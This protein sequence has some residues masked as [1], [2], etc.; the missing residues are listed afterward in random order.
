[1]SHQSSLIESDILK[2]L[3]QQ[4]HKSLLRFITCGSV[5]DGKSTLIGR[6]LYESKLIYDDQLAALETD[7]K[8]MG[9]QGQGIDFALLVDGLASER[10]QG[11]T[12]DVAYRFF[13]TD[14]RKFIVADTPGHEQYTRNMATGASTADLAILMVDA[15][16]GIQTQTRRHST[17]V[18]MLGVGQMVLAINKMDLVGHSQERYQAIVDDYMAFASSIGI[19]NVTAIPVS[20]LQGDNITS[21][22]PNMPWYTGKSLMGFL[23]TVPLKPVKDSSA[24]TMPV[25]WVNRPHLDFR[26]FAGQITTGSISVGDTIQVLPKKVTSTVKSIVTFEN[27]LT[28]AIRGQSVTLTLTD[29]IDISRGDVLVPAESTVQ[30]GSRFLSTLLWMSEDAMVPG[31]SYWVKTRA[32]L[33]SATISVPKHQLNV[34]T[35]EKM[36]ASTLVLN[37]IGDCVCEFDQDIPVSPY[38]DNPHLGSF[39]IIDRATNN[40]VGMGL[41]RTLLSADNWVADHVAH[42][43]KYWQAGLVDAQQ[44]AGRHGHAPLLVVLTGAVSK[45]HVL[46]CATQLEKAVFDAG[47]QVYRHGAQFLR[48]AGDDIEGVRLDMFRQVLDMAHAFLDAG[49][50]FVTSIHSL[51]TDDIGDV[52]AMVAPFDAMV[53]DLNGDDSL[54]DAVWPDAD[55]ALDQLVAR[56]LSTIRF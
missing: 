24:F 4:E 40:T 49:M 27:E 33:C 6:L 31:K 5:D 45:E 28:T 7:S 9:T 36:S 13:S 41:I 32:K 1:M 39:I 15:R 30:V 48:M 20:A 53:V 10:E 54:A 50:V 42:R 18:H 12:I 35:L 55:D 43:Q 3:N 51:S 56:I 37:E 46:D 22:S 8:K 23:E 21:S 38:A 16:H 29:E 47:I 11:I 19:Q 26:G 44:R 17:I 14:K 52:R 34:N 25:Q 2:Y